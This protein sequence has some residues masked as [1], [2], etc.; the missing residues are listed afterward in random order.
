MPVKLAPNN[1]KVRKLEV[2]AE[3][4]RKAIEQQEIDKRAKLREWERLEGEAG[5]AKLGSELAGER[6][7][8]LEMEEMTMD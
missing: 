7:R 8:V 5:A 6:L 3:R 2:E 4:L 1:E